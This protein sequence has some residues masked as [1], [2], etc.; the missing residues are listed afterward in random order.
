M[1]AEA[2]AGKKIKQK[3]NGQKILQVH[4]RFVSST[5]T[6]GFAPM[7]GYRQYVSLSFCCRPH[8]F[9]LLLITVAECTVT[10]YFGERGDLFGDLERPIFS[11]ASALC[12]GYFFCMSVHVMKLLHNF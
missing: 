4:S 3:T 11:A 2:S 7:H 1:C 9:T 6:F 12:S 8:L 10:I 5:M